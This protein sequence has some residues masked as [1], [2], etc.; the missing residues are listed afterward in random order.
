[1]LRFTRNLFSFPTCSSVDGKVR[2]YDMRFGKVFTD[3]IGR[4]FS[5]SVESLPPAHT[6]PPQS[7]WRVWATPA[8][9]IVCLSPLSTANWGSLTRTAARCST[10][11]SC[12]ECVECEGVGCEC[13]ECE[14]VGCECVDCE[15]W[16]WGGVRSVCGV[17]GGVWSVRGFAQSVSP[18]W[19][20]NAFVL[21]KI[22]GFF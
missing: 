1:M 6:H 15:L 20:K 13:V 7:L 19:E 2:R 22:D 16:V 12:E 4:K 14:G 8:M 17:W 9:A 11:E 3:T 21:V 18:K 5:F 10:S